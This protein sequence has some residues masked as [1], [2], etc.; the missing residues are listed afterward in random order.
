MN[1]T[2]HRSLL[3]TA[4]LALSSLM[5]CARVA[6]STKG[7]PNLDHILLEVADLKTSIAFYHDLLGLPVKSNDGHFAML[8]AGN[9]A[10]ALWDKRQD[11]EAPRT[12]GE[13]QGLGMYPHLKVGNVA[14]LK[15]DGGKPVVK[16]GRD[17]GLT[18]RKN[19][20]GKVAGTTTGFVA[21][22]IELVHATGDKLGLSCN[23]QFVEGG[24]HEICA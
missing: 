14:D 22:L 12:S 15:A 21:P 13:R 11:W 16:F 4:L 18:R 9:A 3:L 6:N 23:T 1:I 19:F 17:H 24:V 20:A 5:G 2:P 8:Q 7:V 10:V